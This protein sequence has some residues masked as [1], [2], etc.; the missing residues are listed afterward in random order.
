MSH[1]PRCPLRGCVS[2]PGCDM[3][4]IR[5]RPVLGA[6]VAQSS[7]WDAEHAAFPALSNGFK[8]ETREV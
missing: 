7:P 8:A 1:E 4:E 6:K 5:T 2:V 3:Q